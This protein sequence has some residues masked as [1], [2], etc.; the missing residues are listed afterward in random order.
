[1]SKNIVFILSFI[2]ICL[3]GRSQ[4]VPFYNHNLINPF[5]YNPAMTG[6]SGDVNAYV[7][8]NQRYMG[9]GTGAINNYLSVEG[10]FLIPKSGLGLNISQHSIGIQQQLSAQL[11]Y[12]Y[13][14][15][16]NKLN[17]LRFGVSGG[18]LDNRIDLSEINVSHTDDP[19]LMGLQPN[20]ASYD[21]NAG[22]VYQ[23]KD[24][25]FGV[26]VP[27]LIGN[28]VMYSKENTRGYYALARHFM[29]TVEHD[30]K[31]MDDKK[32]VLT[33]QALVRYIPGAPLQYDVTAQ[34]DHENI[35]WFSATYKSD[36][37]LQFNL[38]FHIR[39]SVHV[40][41]SYE[42][43]INT[44]KNNYS[45]VNHEFLLGYTFDYFKKVEKKHIIDPR[46]TEENNRLKQTVEEKDQELAKKDREMEDE[47]QRRVE[48]ELKKRLAELNEKQNEQ[49]QQEEN[50]VTEEKDEDIEDEDVEE[51]EIREAVGYHFVE[52]DGE[53]SPNGLYVV[54]GVYS[55]RK[56]ADKKLRRVKSEFPEAY[57]V[58]NKKMDYNYIVINYTNN[59]KSAYKST[60]KF[61]SNYPDK[62][63]WILNYIK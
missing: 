62:S 35:G 17:H 21:F 54:A 37:A 49:E 3:V 1:M 32:L 15:R 40:G 31:F 9:Y 18:Y 26:S 50:N 24:T 30:F 46:L 39:N 51:E 55:D 28:K 20:V 6:Y 38:G 59:K 44:F 23:W 53:D 41:Y 5:I 63:V 22:L 42:Y 10:N 2:F 57:I 27:Q 33:P 4:Q 58:I 16:I 19:F 48:E 29:G 13:N 34:I 11:S 8:R 60:Q 45:G 14:L 61:R 25:R 43:I 47:I 12:S 36:Y 7:V 52:L 56:H